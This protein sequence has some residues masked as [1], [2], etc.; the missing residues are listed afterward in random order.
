MLCKK[1]NVR[2]RHVISFDKKD[3]YEFERCPM[4]RKESLKIPILFNGM[5]EYSNERKRKNVARNRKGF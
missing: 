1:C 3:G 5:E 2:M 4:C